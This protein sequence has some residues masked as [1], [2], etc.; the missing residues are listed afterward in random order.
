MLEADINNIEVNDEN[1][2]ETIKSKFK[3]LEELDK[4]IITVDKFDCIDKSS[5]NYKNLDRY[6]KKLDI[7]KKTK[8]HNR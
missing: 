6:Y 5:T 8:E 3:T 7:Q 4:F 1:F 2:M